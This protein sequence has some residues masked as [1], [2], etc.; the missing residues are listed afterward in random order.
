MSCRSRAHPGA[1]LAS[2][3]DMPETRTAIQPRISLTNQ[4]HATRRAPF[5]ES[6]LPR[7]APDPQRTSPAQLL[8]C[9]PIT[10]TGLPPGISTL[11]LRIK[12]EYREMPGLKLT[13]AQARRL[14]DLDTHTCSLV[15]ETLI[16]Q[17]F[18]KC[19]ATGTYIRATG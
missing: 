15:L 17:R 16:E 10:G 9:I 13:E 14:W 1:V 11:L 12:S 8:D 3:K 18:L 4:P 7:S 2:P 5:H 6:A 19:T